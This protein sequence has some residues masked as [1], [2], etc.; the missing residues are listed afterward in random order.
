MANSFV[1][2]VCSYARRKDMRVSIV[3]KGGHL[4]FSHQ[5][6]LKNIY[7]TE[8]YMKKQYNSYIIK[9]HKMT[10]IYIFF[11]YS[12]LSPRITAVLNV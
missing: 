2:A 5:T 11:F 1:T 9:N 7:I 6:E 4:D 12:I 10:N 8:I 3:F